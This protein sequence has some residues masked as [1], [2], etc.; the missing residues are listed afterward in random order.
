MSFSFCYIGRPDAV[1]R[2]LDDFCELLKGDSK[3][4]FEAV[5]PAINTI[6]DQ[7]VN[8][9]IINVRAFGHAS[10]TN[11]VKTFGTCTVEVKQLEG[12]LAQ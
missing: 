11:G 8:D 12:L 4:E 10:F 2:K 3:V 9:G 1:K 6:I 5:K 7:N